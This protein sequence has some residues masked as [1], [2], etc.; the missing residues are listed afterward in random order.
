V[1]PTV[2]FSTRPLLVINEESFKGM[3]NLQYLEIGHWSEI[4][5][6]SKIDLPQG[7]VYLPLKLK[8][9]KW[10]YCP[11]KSLPSTFKAE[12]LVNLIMKYSKLEK[13]WEGTLV[14][15]LNFY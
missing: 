6:W 10:N 5:L 15:I 13:L 14:R 12:Y 8:L 4:G 7:L 2:L 9:L 1:P 3:R 11:L